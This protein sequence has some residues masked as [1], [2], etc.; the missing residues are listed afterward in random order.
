MPVPSLRS[1][2]ALVTGA[3]GFLGSHLCRRLLA[4]GAEVHATSRS[5]RESAPHLRWWQSDLAREGAASALLR[6]I[7]PDFVFHLAGQVSAAPSAALVLTAFESLVGSTV[8]LL[9]ACAEIGCRRL[10]VT[11]LGAPHSLPQ[12]AVGTAAASLPFTVVASA[13]TGWELV[14]DVCVVALFVGLALAKSLN[15]GQ[16]P[17]R[18]TK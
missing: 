17:T 3:A 16:G 13:M 14:R 15:S 9:A 11:G 12:W 18:P 4:E 10:V 8:N 7:R 1:A 5:A 6:E 2:R